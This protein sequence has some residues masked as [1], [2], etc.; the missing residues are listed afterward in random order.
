VLS[1]SPPYSFYY[2]TS[3]D[4]ESRLEISHCILISMNLGGLEVLKSELN[5]I[6]ALS[7]LF[8][9]LDRGYAIPKMQQFDPS[10]ETVV[11]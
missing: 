4:I 9:L 7:E 10:G 11:P 8:N 1:I 2:L 6:C 5:G 3:S